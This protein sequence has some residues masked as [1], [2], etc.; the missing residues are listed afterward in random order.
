[1]QQEE[2]GDNSPHQ[3]LDKRPGI[4]FIGSPNVGKRTLLSRMSL[5]RLSLLSFYGL[6]ICTVFLFGSCMVNQLNDF[7]VTFLNDLFEL[8]YITFRFLENK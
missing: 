6:W 1:M 3:S 5:L 8:L 4:I 2:N 7:I